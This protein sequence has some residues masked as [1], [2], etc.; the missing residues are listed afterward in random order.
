MQRV[1]ISAGSISVSEVLDLLDLEHAGFA[2][3]VANGD[4]L[5]W[6]GSG[7]SREVVEGLPGVVERVLSHLQGKMT[8]DPDD[9]FRKALVEIVEDHAALS[10]AERKRL[11]YD[12][13]VA[14]WSDHDA[15]ISRLT[16]KYALVLDVGV[17]GEEPDYLLWDAVDPRETY[18]SSR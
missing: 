7:I 11:D 17:E 3:G 16:Q 9:R 2:E 18:G 6:L 8:R 15:I 12:V 13:P 1:L 14:N 5:F 4:Y 10:D